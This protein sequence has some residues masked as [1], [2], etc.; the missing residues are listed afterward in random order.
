M[1]ND[2]VSRCMTIRYILRAGLQHLPPP[3]LRETSV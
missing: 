3:I 1:D 2:D